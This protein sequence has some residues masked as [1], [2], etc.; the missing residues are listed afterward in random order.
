V[1]VCGLLLYSC[2]VAFPVGFSLYAVLLVTLSLDVIIPVIPDVLALLLH[3]VTTGFCV[4]RGTGC[5]F[6]CLLLAGMGV[7]GSN[8]FLNGLVVVLVVGGA[9]FSG[10]CQKPC[11]G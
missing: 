11:W 1:W 9:A 5:L 3:Y 8:S 10:L 2:V 7:L 6:I 4:F